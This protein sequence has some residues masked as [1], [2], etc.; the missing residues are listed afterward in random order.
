MNQGLI[1]I[2]VAYWFSEKEAKVYLTILNLWPSSAWAISRSIWEKRTT[3][4]SILK[5]MVK[6]WYIS[7][8]EKNDIFQYSAVN[9]EILLWCLEKKYL[10][11]KSALPLLAAAS[12][13]YWNDT[14]IQYFQWDEGLWNLF[15]DFANSDIEVKTFA[16]TRKYNHEILKE[17][18]QYYIKTRNEKWLGYKRI[19]SKHNIEWENPETEI[20]NIK[21]IKKKDKEFNRQTAIVENFCDIKADIDI[22]WPNKVS[23]LFFVNNVPNIIIISNKMI[24]D[25]LNSI[26]DYIRSANYKN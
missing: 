25:C 7:E 1:D 6:K 24:Y 23:F 4:Y 22:Y 10:D 13:K 19:I 16:G 9:P 5:E 12:N 8:I 26:F 21:D 2:L 15:T 11:F 18:S 20:E 3:T 17:K 14:E